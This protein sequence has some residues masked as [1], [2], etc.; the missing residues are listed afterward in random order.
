MLRNMIFVLLARL[1]IACLLT[2]SVALSVSGQSHDRED[3]RVDVGGAVL[4]VTAWGQGESVV[5][6][7]GA[8][9]SAGDY[10][11]LGP[12][13]AA[14][15][16]R[17]F[18]VNARGVRG[19][20]GSLESLTLHDYAKDVAR[21]IDR[22]GAGRAHVFGPAVGGR[23]ARCVA[24]DFPQQAATVTV[25]AAGGKVPG[26]PEASAAVER[27]FN[28]AAI[29]REELRQIA[30]SALLAPGSDPSTLLAA[31]E[32]WAAARAAVARAS[33]ATPVDDWW[34]GGRVPMLVIQGRNDRVAPVAN[35]RLLKEAAPGRVTLVELENTGHMA[36]FERPTE[37][38]A[39]AVEFWRRH[40][41][42]VSKP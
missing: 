2:G 23:I 25:V 1:L 30:Q 37:V 5:L 12:A 15:G 17:V 9:G 16:F 31:R 34:L 24:T 4:N 26:D 39:A 8:G 27:Y 21:L 11:V 41:I 40:P 19:S 32:N 38:V 20:S 22:V 29:T 3:L 35:G 13:L 7:S 18:A 14:K 33:L 42:G 36:V 28:D 6:I 10:E